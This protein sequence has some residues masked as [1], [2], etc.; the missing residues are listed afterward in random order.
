MFF[1]LLT[2]ASFGVNGQDERIF[3]GHGNRIIVA[4]LFHDILS[5][6]C[7]ILIQCRMENPVTVS[8]KKIINHSY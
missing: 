1:L 3:V 2:S 4:P 5:D 7:G 6:C 8:E